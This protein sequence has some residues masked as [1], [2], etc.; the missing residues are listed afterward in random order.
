MKA[1]FVMKSTLPMENHVYNVIYMAV[2]GFNAQRV[3][4]YQYF[5]RESG[6]E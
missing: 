1:S 4:K 3:K 6:S 2:L 5:P